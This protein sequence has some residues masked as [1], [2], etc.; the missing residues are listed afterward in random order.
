MEITTIRRPTCNQAATATPAP[1]W[2]I[3]AGRTQTTAASL[4]HATAATVPRSASTTSAYRSRAPPRPRA[5][6]GTIAAQWM[7]DV[8]DLSPVGPA[9]GT[10]SAIITFV[11]APPRLRAIQGTIA[12]Q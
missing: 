10:I 1:R 11:L 2:G 3:S 12:A 8:A 7:M 9:L 4:S 6:V 5:G